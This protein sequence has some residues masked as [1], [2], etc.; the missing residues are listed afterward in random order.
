MSKTYIIFEGESTTVKGLAIVQCYAWQFTNIHNWDIWLSNP[1][2][3]RKFTVSYSG[4]VG[5]YFGSSGN[6]L[7]EA[8]AFFRKET[9]DNRPILNY[10]KASVFDKYGTVYP[11]LHGAE[12]AAAANKDK[13]VIAQHGLK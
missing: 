7:D 13:A 2:G 12:I 1:F 3:T 11:F 9:G 4:S 8:L 6:T 10:H 5:N